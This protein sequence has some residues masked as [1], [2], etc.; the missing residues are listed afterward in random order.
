MEIQCNSNQ[1]CNNKTC[2]FECKNY[3]ICKKDY[4]W[5]PSTCI[6]VNSKYFKSNLQ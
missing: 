5:N 2:Q 6:C 3:H 4:S 1:K